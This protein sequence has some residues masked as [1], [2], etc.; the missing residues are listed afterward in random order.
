[1][2]YQ[3]RQSD[4]HSHTTPSNFINTTGQSMEIKASV[5]Y[6]IYVLRAQAY[7]H[8]DVLKSQAASI[9]EHLGWR[10]YE[11]LV[12]RCELRLDKIDS[13]FLEAVRDSEVGRFDFSPVYGSW[14]EIGLDEKLIA[15][16]VVEIFL[17]SFERTVVEWCT[18]LLSS[19]E[20]DL[21]ESRV[22]LKIAKDAQADVAF[23]LGLS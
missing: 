18:F 1:M 12:V 4:Q 6:G 14:S 16:P 13:F 5:L 17:L 20:M 9:T 19:A 3:L 7:A 23:I 8:A 2:G 21:W 11:E 15:G 10:N 22:F